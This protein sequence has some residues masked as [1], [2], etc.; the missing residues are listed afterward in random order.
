[1]SPTR[2]H[3]LLARPLPSSEGARAALAQ[4]VRQLVDSTA[5]MAAEGRRRNLQSLG[6]ST[7]AAMYEVDS[8]AD[9]GGSAATLVVVDL[10]DGQAAPMLAQPQGVGETLCGSI[11]ELISLHLIADES[12][13]EAF[14]YDI[15]CSD[16]GAL[17]A[18][19]ASF[20]NLC[21][22]IGSVGRSLASTVL[23]IALLGLCF[24]LCLTALCC[25]RFRRLVRRDGDDGDDDDDEE[26]WSQRDVGYMAAGTIIVKTPPAKA[27]AQAARPAVGGVVG[28]AANAGS[29]AAALAA[30]DAA[31]GRRA[32]PLPG[33]RRRGDATGPPSGGR[34]SGPRGRERACGRAPARRTIGRAAP[35]R[36]A[37]ALAV[38][39]RGRGDLGGGVG[40]PRARRRGA[41][42]RRR[43]RRLLVPT[44]AYDLLQP[45]DEAHRAAVERGQEGARA[46]FRHLVE[47]EEQ[48]ALVRSASSAAAPRAASS[49]VQSSRAPA[50]R[51][52]RRRRRRRGRWAG[53]ARGGGDGV[54][55]AQWERE[56]LAAEVV[57]MVHRLTR[58]A[59]ATSARCVPQVGAAQG[60]GGGGVAVPLIEEDAAGRRAPRRQGRFGRRLGSSKGRGGADGL[61][62]SRRRL[63]RRRA[64][65]RQCG[66]GRR[67]RSRLPA[68]PEGGEGAPARVTFRRAVVWNG[69]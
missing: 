40:R 33:G 68:P 65:G 62:V 31:R 8:S 44:D 22:L 16:L 18:P 2:V 58:V 69:R 23:A 20:L 19:G 54:G 52:R 11:G 55:S 39:A 5:Q 67:R 45:P 7:A 24:M 9:G 6:S 66:G 25:A 13:H 3:L 53:A 61:S 63:T 32:A 12:Y 51:R 36:A 42:R 50:P 43:R 29:H 60:V 38:A 41:R 27:P 21:G 34:A 1:M 28:G 57:E 30:A 4:F 17:F 14:S 48:A 56:T 15:T 37:Q 35:R 26:G 46:F 10:A 64:G 47:A 49:S 59:T